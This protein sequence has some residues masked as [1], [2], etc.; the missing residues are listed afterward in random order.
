MNFQLPSRQVAAEEVIQA[1]N[2]SD[3]SIEERFDECG[4][5]YFPLHV[6]KRHDSKTGEGRVF[7]EADQEKDTISVSP[8]W[9]FPS[10]K[11][12]DQILRTLAL[13]VTFKRQVRAAA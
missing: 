2:K 5:V 11:Q 8:S 13:Y 6:N 10:S 9:G 3:L 4:F 7:W 12:Q 1:F